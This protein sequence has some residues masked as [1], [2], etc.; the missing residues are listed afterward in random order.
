[1]VVFNFKV[2]LFKCRFSM[3][4]LFLKGTLNFRSRD[5]K[6]GA[7]NALMEENMRL[8]AENKSMKVI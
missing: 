2:I 8:L 7:D 3:R 5:K 6:K 1:M 4:L